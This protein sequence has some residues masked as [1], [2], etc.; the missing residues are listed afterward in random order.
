MSAA[1][2]GKRLSLELFEDRV[3]LVDKEVVSQARKI[4]VIKGHR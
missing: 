1:S 4:L 3:E 2:G